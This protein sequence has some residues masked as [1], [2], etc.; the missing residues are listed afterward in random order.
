VMTAGRYEY[1]GM[2][3]PSEGLSLVSPVMEPSI[4]TP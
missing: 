1:C 4:P 2:L 3:I